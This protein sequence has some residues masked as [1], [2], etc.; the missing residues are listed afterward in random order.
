MRERERE[1]ERERVRESERER[2][3][4]L[5]LKLCHSDMMLTAYDV[6]THKL[7]QLYI[8]RERERER[9]L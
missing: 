4:G 9:S 7:S 3:R 6:Y 2:E 1:S 5:P 8:E